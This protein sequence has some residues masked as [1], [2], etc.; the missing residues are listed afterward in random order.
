L[1]VKTGRGFYDWS[2]RDASEVEAARNEE[3]ARQLQR[4][5]QSKVI[6]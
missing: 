2:R 5:R 1:G 4:L 3:I 6:P